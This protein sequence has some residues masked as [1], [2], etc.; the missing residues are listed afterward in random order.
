MRTDQVTEVDASV[1]CAAELVKR[2]IPSLRA[3]CRELLV[4]TECGRK[5]RDHLISVAARAT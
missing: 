4:G 2:E 1:T 3:T 5:L